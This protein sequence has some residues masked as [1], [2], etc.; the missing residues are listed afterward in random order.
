MVPYQ[1]LQSATSADVATEKAL[2]LLKAS[3]AQDII[4]V[5]EAAQKGHVSGK[6]V[7][8]APVKD[9]GDPYLV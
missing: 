1:G 4:Q 3:G 5:A 9:I 6:P 2:Q 7:C 8:G